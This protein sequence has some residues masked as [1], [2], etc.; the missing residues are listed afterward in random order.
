M[1]L[2]DA[3]R[4]AL[5]DIRLYCPIIGIRAQTLDALARRELIVWKP[6]VKDCSGNPGAWRITKSGC[7]A[8][9]E[10]A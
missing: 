2:T 7:A 3:Q 4:D 5:E 6:N 1:T 9:V 8:I 10:R